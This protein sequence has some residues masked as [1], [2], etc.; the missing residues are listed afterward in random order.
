MLAARLDL[1]GHRRRD[2]RPAAPGSTRRPPATRRSC[3]APPRPQRLGIGTAGPDDPGL[4]SAAGGSPWSASST[5]CRSRRS[6]TPPPWSAGT[7]AET[8]PRLRRAPDDRLHPV[9]RRARSRRSAAVLAATAN[10]EAPERGQGLPALRRA[11]RPA[12]HRRRPSPGCCSASARSPCWS[13]ASGWPT[14]WSSRC[15]NGGPRSGCAARSA[16]PGARSGCSSSPSRCCC[17]R[18][19]GSA[20]CCSGIAVTAGRTPLSQAWPAVVPAWATA[21][22]RRRDPGHRRRRRP[23][24]G[25][26]GRP[27]RPDRGPRRHLTSGR[28]PRWGG[29]ARIGKPRRDGTAPRPV[30][31]A[32]RPTRWPHAR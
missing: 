7:A 25:D 3:S 20:G 12:G 13:A 19:A 17:R 31:P 9:R 14:R 8:V 22:R 24:P 16:R 18:S 11:G 32:D 30:P 27:A 26:P 23:L 2:R 28:A 15:S 4:R 29:A 21:R 1:L 10:P 6:W 5:R